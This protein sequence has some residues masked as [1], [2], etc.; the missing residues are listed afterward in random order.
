MAETLLGLP[1]RIGFP[2][3]IKGCAD[4]MNNPIYATGAGLVLYGYGT[5]TGQDLLTL[6][7]LQGYSGK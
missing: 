1:V 3:D 5:G 6:M 4:I 2:R 7:L